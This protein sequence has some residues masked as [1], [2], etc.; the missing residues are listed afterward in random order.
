MGY[1]FWSGV[2]GGLNYLL[3]HIS[4]RFKHAHHETKDRLDKTKLK[5]S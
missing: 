3:A 1:S 4:R 2:G 5:I